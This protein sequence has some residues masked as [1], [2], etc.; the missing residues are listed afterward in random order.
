M[1]DFTHIL[2]LFQIFSNLLLIT[3]CTQITT[4]LNFMADLS[5]ETN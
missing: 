3:D 1:N 2:Q 4:V 5:Q